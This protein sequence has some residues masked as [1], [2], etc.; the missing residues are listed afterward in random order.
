MGYLP[1]GA[2][3]FGIESC[4][5]PLL[6]SSSNDMAD[7]RLQSLADARRFRCARRT[8]SRL[9]VRKLRSVFVSKSTPAGSG[10]NESGPDPGFRAR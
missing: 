9:A 8:L 5:L 6:G 3:Y 4:N 10:A 1:T 2:G 7:Q